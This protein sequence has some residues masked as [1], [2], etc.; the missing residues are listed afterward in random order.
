MHTSSFE[1][2]TAQLFLHEV[3]LA[4]YADFVADNASQRHA[5][6]TTM[7]AYHLYEWIHQSKFTIQD[8]QLRYPANAALADSFEVARK[9]T[10]GTK[11]FVSK[12]Q[13]RAQRGFSSAFNDGFARPLV[14]SFP[15]GN[16]KSMDAF[17]SE[18]V[19]FWKAEERAGAF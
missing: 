16:E 15:N 6:L 14:V 18:M 4:E 17:L 1:I 7:V 12:V 3:V 2:T 19:E 11:H 5:L 13:T 8:F 9:I 10:N